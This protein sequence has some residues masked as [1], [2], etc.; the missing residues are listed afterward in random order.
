MF[1]GICR[2]SVVMD[3]WLKEMR[4]AL[5]FERGTIGMRIMRME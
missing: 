4:S 5:Y 1:V 2:W 3:E